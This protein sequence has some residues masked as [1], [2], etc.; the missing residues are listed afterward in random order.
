MAKATASATSEPAHET[1]DA[2][3]DDSGVQVKRSVDKSERD[4]WLA[5]RPDWWRAGMDKAKRVDPKGTRRT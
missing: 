3:S 5:S 4:A 1:N 2:I